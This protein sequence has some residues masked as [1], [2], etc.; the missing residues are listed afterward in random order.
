MNTNY[1]HSVC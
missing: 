1:H